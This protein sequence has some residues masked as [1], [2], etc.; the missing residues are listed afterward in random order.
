MHIM[1]QAD[2][3][4]VNLRMQSV[5]VWILLLSVYSGYQKEEKHY[6]YC[7]SREFDERQKGIAVWT[8]FLGGPVT[9]KPP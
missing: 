6:H 9:L 8:L 5:E 7:D 1:T 3:N 4:I 2:W